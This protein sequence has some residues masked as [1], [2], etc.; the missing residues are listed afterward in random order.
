MT[1]QRVVSDSSQTYDFV[2]AGG[3]IGGAAFGDGHA[4]ASKEFLGLVFVDVHQIRC[5]GPRATG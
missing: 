1:E 5:L 4:V 3:G 2:V